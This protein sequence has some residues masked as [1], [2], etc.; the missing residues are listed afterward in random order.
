YLYDAEGNLTLVRD[1]IG[2]TSR[3]YGYDADH[4]LALIGGTGQPCVV[5]DASGTS[6]PVTADL[7]V[8]TGYLAS[9]HQGVLAPGG[10]D[11]LT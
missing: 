5:I 11:R 7:G 1:L 8:A 6:L 9:A 10:T 3:N 2:A 4:R